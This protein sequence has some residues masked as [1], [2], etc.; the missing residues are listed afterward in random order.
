MRERQ[1]TALKG[2]RSCGS[3]RGSERESARL[4]VVLALRR[5]EEAGGGALGGAARA[6]DWRR[7]EG[8]VL[9]TGDG[10]LCVRY[11]GVRY[12]CLTAGPHTS[13][14]YRVW[15]GFS[16]TGGSAWRRGRNL[17]YRVVRRRR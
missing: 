12:G 17:G 15:T 1:I 3:E 10:W 2:R 13:Y 8:A 5:R 11:G 16:P 6:A 7:D 4:K 14:T 9:G